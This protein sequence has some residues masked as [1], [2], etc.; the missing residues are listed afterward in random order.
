[1]PTLEQ[2]EALMKDVGD[3]LNSMPVGL[4]EDA[5]KALFASMF[6]TAIKDPNGEF[7]RKM[8]FGAESPS[9][10][11]G[12]KFAVYK[13][14]EADVEFANDLLLGAKA[15]GQSKGGP[16]E[17]LQNAFK[18]VSA[19]R[20]VDEATLR[21]MNIRQME[22]M[23]PRI[24]KAWHPEHIAAMKAM[25]SAE[26]GYGSSLIGAQYVGDLWD[27]ARR[28]SRVWSLFDTLEMSD[29]TAY[30]PVAADIPELMFVSEST[31]SNSSNFTTTKTGS[32]RVT[33][34][35][36]KFAVHQMWSGELEEDSIIPFVPFLRAQLAYALAHYMDSLALNGDTT[37][38]GT[39]NINLDDA[40][41][42]DTKHYLAFD[43][44]RHAGIV[45]NTANKSDVAGAITLAALMGSKARMLDTTYLNDW[46][47]PANAD[48]LVYVADPTTVDKIAM[49]DQVLTVDKYGPRA[50]ILT[51]EQA[52]VLG[53]PLIGSMAMSLTEAD[54]KVSTTGS[55][56]TKGQVVAFN[57]RAFKAGWRRQVRIE[58][59]RL[60]ASD[61]NRIVATLRC[62][63]GRYS[64]TGAASGIEAADVLYNISL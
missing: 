11:V 23:L 42:A 7:A 34:T 49:L 27:S 56:N 9:K 33:L 38:A 18:A 61:Q 8:R 29:P 64:P 63:F 31:A 58:T 2:I 28:E 26:S 17:E 10:L 25:D 6:E 30:V 54:G 19:A 22:G 41:P 52:R 12:S 50:T 45:D 48:D 60:P 53:H 36:K 3:R 43:G 57:R 32:N 44:I 39:G 55:N 5:V 16:S 21:A 14:T 51:G 47:H 37:N 46:G 15:S 59:E 35:A 62:A 4:G 1:M 40:D 20:Y 24:P 13:W